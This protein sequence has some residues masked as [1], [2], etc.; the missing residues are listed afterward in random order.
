VLYPKGYS[1]VQTDDDKYIDLRGEID[2]AI[3]NASFHVIS[4]AV[5]TLN[6]WYGKVLGT[7]VDYA[8]TVRDNNYNYNHNIV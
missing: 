6:N 3:K 7:S 5:E 4:V 1:D 8:S 2:E